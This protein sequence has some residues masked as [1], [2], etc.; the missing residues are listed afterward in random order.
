MPDFVELSQFF[1]ADMRFEL[2]QD[3]EAIAAYEQAITLY[4]EH[5]RAPWARYQM[6]LIYRRLGDDQKALEAFN[7][8]VELAKVRPGELWEPLAKENQRDLA[9][10]LDYQEYLKQ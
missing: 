5:D 3:R 7:T 8:L 4:G 2:G 6:G 10:K 1:T 9:T